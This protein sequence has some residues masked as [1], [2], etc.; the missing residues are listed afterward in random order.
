MSYR[1]VASESPAGRGKCGS[2][3]AVHFLRSRVQAA[4][5]E[6][7]AGRSRVE[8]R[9]RILQRNDGCVRREAPLPACVI[10]L[11]LCPILVQVW[12]V[13][14]P[15]CVGGASACAYT[16]TGVRGRHVCYNHSLPFF[17]RQSLSLNLE[18]TGQTSW[19]VGPRDPVSAPPH[20]SPDCKRTPPC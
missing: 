10:A 18:L 17:L 9:Q 5:L 4:R 7:R 15:L 3:E 12:C 8:V 14:H 1:A 6:G 20:P 16:C 2:T 19:L 13:R 11:A